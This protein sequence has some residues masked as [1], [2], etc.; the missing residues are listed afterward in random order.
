MVWIMLILLLLL[1]GIL[2]AAYYCYRLVFYSQNVAEQDHYTIPPGKQYEAV[3]ER[4]LE[5]VGK[6]DRI[7][8]EQ[9]YITARDG[10]K[11]AGRYYSF[12]T[13]GPVQ[14]QFHGY[15]GDPIREYSGGCAMAMELGYNVL[16]VDQRA[17]GKS[18]GHTITFGIKERYD[19]LDWANYVVNRFGEET[20]IFLSGIS[21]GAA[22]VLMASELALPKEVVAITAD[23]PYSSPGAIIRKVCRDVRLPPWLCY[24]FVI[25]GG[26]LY[27]GFKIWESSPVNAVK[28]TKIPIHII[29]GEDDRFVP[30]D[31]SREILAAANGPCRL[32][33]VPE[34]GHGLSMLVDEN[35]YNNAFRSFLIEC[36]I[37]HN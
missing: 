23:C 3:A 14:I 26:L 33:T 16:V 35:K 21:M 25:L 36:G 27:G 8:Y 5:L 22:T 15:R 2:W 28:N 9:V 4:M 17:H 20:K 24:P 31:M 18:G 30:C 1:A 37:G 11:L 32:I 10:T 13:E 19:C 7:P 12:H 29:H 6:L 34:A